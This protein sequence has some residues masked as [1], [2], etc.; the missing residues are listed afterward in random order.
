MVNDTDVSVVPEP[1]V[2]IEQAAGAGL[3]P[4]TSFA[5]TSNAYCCCNHKK[6]KACQGKPINAGGT[7]LITP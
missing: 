4:F 6:N 3:L 2:C 1:A 7:F 5:N